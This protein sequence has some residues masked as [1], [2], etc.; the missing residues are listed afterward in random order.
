[1]I[2]IPV[3]ASEILKM[4]E[5]AVGHK[6]FL[7]ATFGRGGHTRLLMER[8]PEMK[9]CGLDQD[10]EAIEYGNKEFSL[11]I[12]Q[13]VMRLIHGNFHNATKIFAA[14]L[15]TWT[16]GRGFDL[17]LVDLGVSSPQLDQSQRGFSFYQ[18]G[19]LDMRMDQSQGFT[20]A[21][22]VNSWDENDLLKLFH[23][24]GEIRQPT[25]VVKSILKGRAS[26]PFRT[27]QQLASLIESI[28]GWHKKGHHPATRYFLALRMEVNKELEGLHEAMHD[29]IEILAE[30]GRLMILT[31][32]SLEDRIVKYAL[33]E[34][35]DRGFLVNKKVV[36]PSREEEVRNRRARSAKLRVFQ[37]G[38]SHE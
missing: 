14:E 10:L 11:P 25:K 26:K 31:F 33:R 7:D 3:M 22:L 9:V 21:D 37:K 35:L 17:I 38:S 32:H 18:D 1:M 29:L 16:E 30:G 23:E 24:Y 28:E 36:Q 27:T 5:G 13:G 6:F 8:F 34:R 4:S 19:P 20:A 12:N 2:H 15:K